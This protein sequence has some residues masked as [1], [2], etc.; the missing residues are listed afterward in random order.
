M[1]L[2]DPRRPDYNQ[3]KILAEHLISLASSG[4]KRDILDWAESA[5]VFPHSDR[6]P[7]FKRSFAP[8]FNFPLTEFASGKWR[9]ISFIGPTGAGKTTFIETVTSYVICLDAGPMLI[10]GQ[11]DEDIG[12]WA[13]ERLMPMLTQMPATKSLLPHNRYA[14]K[15][16]EIVFPHMFLRLGGANINT[17]QSKSCRYVF[18]DEVWTFKVGM[19]EEARARLHDRANG[20]LLAL[21]QGGV[22][23]DEHDKLHATCTA[24]EYN[25]RCPN[26]S[27]FNPYATES[28]RYDDARNEKGEWLWPALIASVRIRCPRCAAEFADNETNRYKLSAAGEYRSTGAADAWP[29]RLGLHLHA[30]AIPWIKWSALIL[31]KIRSEE[32][33]LLGDPSALRTFT[34]KREARAWIEADAVV[35]VELQSGGYR[36]SEFE[37]GKPIDGE[38]VRFLTV[39]KGKDHFWFAVRAWRADGSS[40]LLRADRISAWDD[41]IKL[42]AQYKVLHPGV[43]IDSGYDTTSVKSFCASHG[44][45]ALRG[46]RLNSWTHKDAK[47]TTSRKPYSPFVPNYTVD[48]KLNYLVYFSNLHVKDTLQLLRLG[49]VVPFEVPND[50]ST[51]YSLHMSSEVRRDVIG[52]GG[53]LA[54]RWM[55][56]EGRPNHLWDV[57]VMQVCLAIMMGIV[58]LDENFAVTLEAPATEVAA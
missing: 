13:T 12:D 29:D 3:L 9:V 35:T 36:S 56:I 33:A 22:Q 7:A 27:E 20:I 28:L 50:V 5:V 30:A 2:A 34:Q 31:E 48:G 38:A 24:Y 10:V 47:G 46:D 37:D 57:E 15:K 45:L 11:S 49:R 1:V 21:G 44:F 19:V 23:G 17:L 43:A 51:E 54:Q 55:P 26:C 42:Q 16:T 58:R 4:V 52:T 18:L 8:W 39:D 53:D 32:R 40:R 41:I 6:S 25:W 14:I